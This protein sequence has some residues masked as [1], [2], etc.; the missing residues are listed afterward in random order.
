A[1]VAQPVSYFKTENL[2]FPNDV[3]RFSDKVWLAT[4]QGIS[5]FELDGATYQVDVS[6]LRANCLASHNDTLW[7]GANNTLGFFDGVQWTLSSSGLPLPFVDITQISFDDDG[8]MWLVISGA[9]FTYE[10]GQF[11]NQNQ[12]ANLLR[13]KDNDIYITT[14]ATSE[15]GKVRKGGQ[16]ENLPQVL[17]TP[18]DNDPSDLQIDDD[19]VV[20]FSRLH[21]GYIEND[22]VIIIPESF[23]GEKIGVFQNYVVRPQ[24][25]EIRLINASQ[26]SVRLPSL[27]N[28]GQN[29]VS[30]MFYNE[31]QFF[32][33]FNSNNKIC[34]FEWFPEVAIDTASISQEIRFNDFRLGLGSLGWIGDGME[35]I[36]Q[37]ADTSFILPIMNQ[38]P[39]ISAIQD[40][41]IKSSNEPSYRTSNIVYAT[42]PISSR[43][44]SAYVAK[45]SRVWKVTRSEIERHQRR[46]RRNLY[47]APSGIAHWPGNGNVL[48]G[49]APILA[50]FFDRNGNGIY[51]PEL[52][53][54]PEILGDEMIYAIINDH[55]SQRNEANNYT[56]GAEIHVMLYTFD[57]TTHPDLA[58]SV[59]CRYAIFNR[60][61]SDWDSTAFTARGDMGAGQSNYLFG[62]DSVGQYFFHQSD[63]SSTSDVFTMVGG[64]LNH[65]MSGFVYDISPPWNWLPFT[66]I[67]VRASFNA[68]HNF[69]AFS[70]QFG[71]SSFPI[72]P[73]VYKGTGFFPPFAQRDTTILTSWAFDRSKNWKFPLVENFQEDAMLGYANVYLG[74]VPAGESVC[75]DM[76]FNF[77]TLITPD[78]SFDVVDD[79]EGDLQ[80]ARVFYQNQ[81]FSCLHQVLSVD[82]FEA[83]LGEFK[84]FPNP[85]QRGN[86][87]ILQDY[88]DRDFEVVIFTSAGQHINPKTT[89]LGQ[90]THIEIS[91]FVPP[92]IYV[93][94]LRDIS[95][96][97]VLFRK[98]VVVD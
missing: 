45:Y 6:N 26:Q 64:F 14:T 92:G 13:I 31:G 34:L 48:N 72:P 87:I 21:V 18:N 39:W 66:P 11:V 25:N 28:L 82:D 57:E 89:R 83:D 68:A 70:G 76:V 75:V 40:S 88:I 5:Y 51:E 62:S 56:L 61:S 58:N 84:L 98:I 69:A 36:Y 74:A 71:M 67:P 91:S 85:I 41:I 80:N 32:C 46:Y 30:R 97:A 81:D 17:F 2:P 44:D 42:G 9:L 47:R 63:P 65:S 27:L 95:G 90:E 54:Y 12:Q 94:R 77:S 79:L 23:P 38:L 37:Q 33:L 10:N 96:G 8:V 19:G 53:D 43:Y 73:D 52:G 29:G 24:R 1:I 60:S 20:W 86:T 35:A 93:M 15:I 49:E 78:L 55:R 50:P 22:S 4:N 3:L 7:V 59:F 16:W